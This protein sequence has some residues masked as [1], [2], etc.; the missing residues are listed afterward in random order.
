MR[1]VLRCVLARTGRLL[2]DGAQGLRGAQMASSA[3]T[4]PF[5][6][7]Y[8]PAAEELWEEVREVIDSGFLTKGATN[9]SQV[10]LRKPSWTAMVGYGESRL[11]PIPRRG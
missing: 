4:I 10:L 7:P 9:P 1:Q 11:R 6:K 8:L 3:R 5:V 2:R